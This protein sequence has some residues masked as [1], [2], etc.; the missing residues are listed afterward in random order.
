MAEKRGEEEKMLQNRNKKIFSWILILSMVIS[1][2]T[3][4]SALAVNAE[5]VYEGYVYVTVERFTLGQGLAA[6]PKKIGYKSGESMADIL[7][8]GYGDDAIVTST[9]AWGESFDG[10][11]DGGEPEG[12]TPEQIPQKIV[13]ALGVA[14]EYTTAVTIDDIK[15]SGRVKADT[16]SNYDYTGQ[17][18]LMTCI[19]NKSAQYGISGLKAGETDDGTSFHDGSVF[20][21]EF[22]IYN[23]G[24]DLNIAYGST[25]IDFPDKDELIREIVDYTGD[26]TLSVYTDAV[27]VLE[28]WDATE[29]EVEEAEGKLESYKKYAK[30][31]KDAVEKVK[32]NLSAPSYKDEWAVLS[33]ARNG[34]SDDQWNY[35]YI[36]NVADSVKEKGTNVLD[37]T[38]Y[39]YATENARVIIGLNAA[40][41]DPRDVAGYNLLEPLADYTKVSGQGVNGIIFALLAFDSKNYEIP[42]LT[43][44]EGEQATKEKLVNG[45]INSQITG[46]GWDWMPDATTPD[47]DL[48]GMALQALAP[49][50]DTFDYVKETV[51]KAVERLSE[52]Q[53]ADGGYSSWGSANSCSCAQ[54]ICGL[55]ALGIDSDT[56][57]RF[58]KNGKSLLDA[59]LAYYNADDKMFKNKLSDTEGAAYANVQVLYALT[60]YD[61][62]CNQKG[63]LYDMTGVQ[64]YVYRIENAKEATCSEEGYTGD[65]ISEDGII[66]KKGSTITKTSHTPVEIPA[67]AATESTAGKTAGKKCSVC[68]EILEAQEDVPATGKSAGTATKTDTPKS[69]TPSTATQKTDNT[70]TEEKVTLPQAYNTTGTEASNPTVE[71]TGADAAGKTNV[72]IQNT[73][74]A[75]NGAEYKITKVADNAFAGNTTISDVTLGANVTEIGAGAFK[76]CTKL[77][78][79]VIQDGSVTAIDKE[80]FAGDKALTNVDFSECKLQTIGTNAFSGCKKLS[81]IRINGNKLT[82]VGKN[83]FKNIKKNAKIIIYAKNKKTYN[84]A[85]KLIKKSGVKKVKYSFKKKK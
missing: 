26:K 47:P 51:D 16:L 38:G 65:V 75:S 33:V 43:D 77:S 71:Y 48:T 64:S 27:A 10:F 79:V 76:N 80:A 39:S 73:A 52:K 59:T 1:V 81:V 50:Y 8:R 25:L 40:G 18:Y 30:V 15:A 63:R 41:G 29:E 85:V 28:D 68:G 31:H 58:I 9:S 7:K 67:V 4:G 74:K 45:I 42:E 21:V 2:I 49:Y 55:S 6:E 78:N 53:D 13:D 72:T 84:K 57:S 23:Y 60:A 3:P 14:G 32:E 20:R 83:A 12:W 19:D 82:K 5:E 34:L 37:A 61:M 62:M 35:S 46:G 24:G 36:E 54:V 17:S 69:E 66:L 11:V 70:K 56:D 22:G 44:S